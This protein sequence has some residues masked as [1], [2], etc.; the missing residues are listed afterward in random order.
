M[1]QRDADREEFREEAGSLVRIT[2]APLIWA[3]H[4]VICYGAIAVTC[5]KAPGWSGP[6]RLGLIVLTV[7]ALAGIV[8][9][10]LRAIRQWNVAGTGTYSNPEGTGGDRHRFLGHAAFLLAVVSGIGVI[11]VGLPVLMLE[12]CG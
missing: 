1:S 4:F 9:I 3:A 6:V 10:G 2:L 8:W 5:A 7:V 12:G 11:Y